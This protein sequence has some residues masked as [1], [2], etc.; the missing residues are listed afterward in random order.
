VSEQIKKFHEIIET[1]YHGILLEKVR[2]GQNYLVID[3]SDISKH[4]PDLADQLLE[5]PDELIKAFELAI[6]QFDLGSEVKGFKIRIKN[7]PDTQKIWIR[8]IRST[9]IGKLLTVEG[10]VRQKSD[11][12]PQVTSA[13]FECP[14]CGNVISVLQLE[15]RFKEPSRCGCG[16]KGKFI[17][18]SK[19]LIDA[20]GMVLEEAPENLE[21]GEQ[22]KRI[23]VFLKD[24]LVSPISEKRTN[25]GSKIVVVGKV[26]EIPITLHSGSQSVRFDLLIEA[27]YVEAVEEDYYDIV[28]TEEE[29]EKIKELAADRRIYEK[30]VNSVAPSIYGHD[31]VKEAIILQLV[32]GVKKVRGD[33]VITRGDMHVLLIGDPGAGKSQ[34]L[35]RATIVAPKARYVSGKGASGAG[36]TAAVVK[37]EF[38]KGW[39]LEA[40]ALVL[41]NKGLC[42]IDEMD[43]MSVEDRSAMHEA[44]EQQTITISKANIQA[45]LRA[46]T[47]VLAAANPKFGRF[48]P[49][50]IL[51]KQIDL[52][53][54]LISRF[55]LIFPIKD[56]PDQDKDE[57][58]AKHILMLHQTPEGEEPEIETKLLK[59]YI[60]YTRQHASPVLTDS[61]IEEIKKFYVEMRNSVSDESGV[62][63][64]PI[65][66]RQLEA[67]VRMAEANAKIRLSNKV[68]KKDA[69]RAIDILNYCLSQVGIDPETGKIDI[70]RISSGITSSQRNKIFAVKEIIVELE[71]KLGKTI[72]IEDIAKEAS[73]KGIPE[74]EV[75]EVI[76][77]LKRSGDL[78]EPRRG[79]VSRI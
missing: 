10:I 60:A 53:P 56:L 61:A 48:D 1:S 50:D 73:E 23:N 9:H 27:N 30:I 12:R 17:L 44:L 19:E 59:K 63:S 29:K 52:P 49:Y 3:F 14:S 35:K 45:T 57:K 24:D 41:A 79:F 25:P 74:T 65:T 77:K 21:G 39:S 6:E 67:L 38:L 64:V 7:L 54:A 78:F 15:Q 76:E 47:T 31:K 42:C 75:D 68:T 66:A 72:P 4:D 34:L 51:A 69:K 70:D 13:K 58:M 43:K 46:E 16:R 18:L 32:G 28:I 55:D 20:Q 71:N 33:G 40:G 8:D 22:P 26:K 62:K 11:V 36:L 5:T 37:D 2:K